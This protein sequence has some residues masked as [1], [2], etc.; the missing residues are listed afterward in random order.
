MRGVG[1][2]RDVASVHVVR[3]WPAY[4]IT[5]ETGMFCLTV[6]V[7]AIADQGLPQDRWNAGPGAGLGL[8]LLRLATIG[9]ALLAIGVGNWS[10]RVPGWLMLSAL[11]VAA[12][13]QL[14][15]P[16]AETAFRLGLAQTAKTTDTVASWLDFGASWLVW[17]VP[18]GFFA[19]LALDYGRLLRMG[20]RPGAQEPVGPGRDGSLR[21]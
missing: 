17:G 11:A 16:L 10:R 12:G 5:A 20:P 9:L 4:A 19:L 18:G 14:A 8:T 21:A 15:Y 6:L 13:A 2:D 1:P 7:L 3:R